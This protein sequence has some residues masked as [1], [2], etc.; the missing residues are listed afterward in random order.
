M[1]PT[2]NKFVI[3]S[4]ARL[5]KQSHRPK[6]PDSCVVWLCSQNPK[7][8]RWGSLSAN[9]MQR[10]FNSHLKSMAWEEYIGVGTLGGG[11]RVAR[12]GGGNRA[13]D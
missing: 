4:Q 1:M 8:S 6:T 2:R 5:E 12:E 3:A 10:A 7:S 13:K 11:K 9:E